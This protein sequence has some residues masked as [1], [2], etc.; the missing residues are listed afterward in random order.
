M[1]TPFVYIMF[2]IGNEN[3]QYV[4]SFEATIFSQIKL[5]FQNFPHAFYSE[6]LYL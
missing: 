2:K 5:Q 4:I 3:K 6:F 1:T